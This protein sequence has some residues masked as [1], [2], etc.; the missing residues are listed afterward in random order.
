MTDKLRP[1]AWSCRL[2]SCLKQYDKSLK[3]LRLRVHRLI[4]GRVIIGRILIL[5]LTFGGLIFGR[6]CFREGLLSEF[7]GAC[8]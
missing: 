1:S 4:F 6:A 7:Y 8:K 5:R 2:T 3:Q